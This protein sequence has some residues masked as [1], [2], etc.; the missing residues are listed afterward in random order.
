MAMHIQTAEIESTFPKSYEMAQQETGSPL[1]TILLVEDE[2]FVRDVTS[3]VLQAAGYGVLSAKNAT[4]AVHQYERHCGVVDLLLTD[5]V[6]PGESGRTLAHRLQ[7]RNP[8]LQVLLVTGYGEQMTR[9]PAHE[10]ECLPKPFSSAA[11]LQRIRQM[12]HELN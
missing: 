4:E 3:E 5:V 11:L 8:S 10:A 2:T 1:G 9:D 6:L 12:L 7:Q